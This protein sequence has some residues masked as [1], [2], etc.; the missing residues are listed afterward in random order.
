MSTRPDP[1]LGA[2]AGAHVR[3][4]RTRLHSRVNPG[5]SNNSV[6]HAC[7]LQCVLLT[8]FALSPAD[9]KTV[10]IAD[11]FH[12]TFSVMSA[13]KAR[14]TASIIFNMLLISLSKFRLV[15][16][17]SQM[18]YILQLIVDITERHIIIINRNVLTS[19]GKGGMG[20][21]RESERGRQGGPATCDRG[22]VRVGT[23]FALD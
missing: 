11:C 13:S 5:T 7:H 19:G 10:S 12:T 20:G 6:S 17:A 22:Q 8:S 21:Q 3:C 2:C 16:P 4:R 23:R 14:S 9:R 1:E 18:L 15:E